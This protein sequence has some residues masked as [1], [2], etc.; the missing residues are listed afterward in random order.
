MLSFSSYSRMT[1]ISQVCDNF[2]FNEIDPESLTTCEK[3]VKDLK[4]MAVPKDEMLMFCKYRNDTGECD[5]LFEEIITEEGI[6]YTFNALKMSEI[7]RDESITED[8]KFLNH[9]QSSGEDWSMEKG[10]SPTA[11]LTVYPRRALGSGA[12]VGLN[13]LLRLYEYD[14]DYI[15][16]GPVQGFK[17]LLHTPGEMPQV[18]KQYF[19]MPLNQEVLVAIKPQMMTTSEGLRHYPPNRRQCYFNNERQLRFFKVYTQRNCELECLAN[20]TMKECGCVK[21]N[22]PSMGWQR[23][24]EDRKFNIVLLI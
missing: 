22:M 17:I 3:C 6:C 15:C 13:T 2:I 14:L 20:F 5:D 12:R 1:A 8:F 9:N 4:E 18:S 11:P 16:R 7:Y 21:F 23:I 24:C 19:R 10:Y